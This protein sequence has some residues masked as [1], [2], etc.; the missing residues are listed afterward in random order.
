MSKLDKKYSEPFIDLKF[1]LPRVYCLICHKTVSYRSSHWQ[2]H[3]T[4]RGH[5]RKF[6]PYKKPHMRGL[7]ID[8]L[9][10]LLLAKSNMMMVGVGAHNKYTLLMKDIVRKYETHPNWKKIVLTKKGPKP[11]TIF[12]C[13][14]FKRLL[15]EQIKQNLDNNKPNDTSYIESVFLTF[16]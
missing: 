4:F 16:K 2:K 8:L 10:H 1:A 9:Q 13:Y 3:V 14:K 11:V 6:C 5:H 15:V 7:C 12:N